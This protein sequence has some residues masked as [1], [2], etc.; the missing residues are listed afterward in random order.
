MAERLPYENNYDP[1]LPDLDR[2]SRIGPFRFVEAE[3]RRTVEA[4]WSEPGPN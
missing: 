1:S 4:R 3:Y 2:Y